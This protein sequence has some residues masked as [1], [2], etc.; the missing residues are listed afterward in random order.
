MPP[1]EKKSLSNEINI[2]IGQAFVK[3]QFIANGCNLFWG[4]VLVTSQVV[5]GVTT[6]NIK[7][8]KSYENHSKKNRKGIKTSAYE[9][10]R[11]NTKPL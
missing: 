4:G 1:I 3:T 10:G 9:V 8:Q 2:L 7:N 6:D 5:R 11:I